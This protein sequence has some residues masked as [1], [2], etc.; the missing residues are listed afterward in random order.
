LTGIDAMPGQWHCDD[1][2][3]V[4][5]GALF[6]RGED[7][8]V[9]ALEDGRARLRRLGIGP[10]N[11]RSAQVVEGLAPGNQVILHPSDAVKENVK[12]VARERL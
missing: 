2:P 9:Y 11:N 12:V 5:L 3:I 10:R 7:W 4:P 8:A 6:R 1:V